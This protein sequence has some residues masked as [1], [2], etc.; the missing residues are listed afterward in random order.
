MGEEIEK[1]PC[2]IC[3]KKS[4]ELREEETEVPYFG[5]MFLFSM[6]CEECKYY[7]ADMEALEKQEPCKWTF[8]VDGEEDLKVRVIKS[9]EAT[10]KIPHVASI[11]PGPAS[12]GYIT[13]VEGIINRIKHQIESARDSEEDNAVK[14]KAKNMLK[15]L[16]ACPTG[17]F[18]S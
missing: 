6:A 11:T 1:A 14:K 16:Q 3:K 4:L 8:E 18:R 9:A 7:K 2:P 13:N 12:N 15:K 10:V 17:S 5:K